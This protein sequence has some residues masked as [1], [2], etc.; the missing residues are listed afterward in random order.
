MTV[1]NGLS[2]GIRAREERNYEID[3]EDLRDHSG[4]LSGHLMK[5]F[6]VLTARDTKDNFIHSAVFLRVIY[7]NYD[8]KTH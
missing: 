3:S 7:Y 2:M 6:L 4:S 5:H 1:P 8:E